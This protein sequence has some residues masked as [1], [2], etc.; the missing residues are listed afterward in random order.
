MAPRLSLALAC[1]DLILGEIRVL[2]S[3][4]NKNCDMNLETER[5]LIKPKT[6]KCKYKSKG[7]F[8]LLIN[9]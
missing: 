3:S 9:T 1:W 7:D 4:I 2:G 6:G 8:F 5:K